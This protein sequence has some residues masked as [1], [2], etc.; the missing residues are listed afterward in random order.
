MEIEVFTSA[1]RHAGAD[2]LYLYYCLDGECTIV[3]ED[4]TYTLQKKDIVVCNPGQNHQIV[5]RQAMAVQIRFP[6]SALLSENGE[7][8][9]YISCCSTG[10][11]SENMER[12]RRILDR[13]LLQDT[14]TSMGRLHSQRLG[15]ELLIFLLS[16]F[17]INSRYTS[18]QWDRKSQIR[19]YLQLHFQEDLS[20]DQMADAFG[21]SSVYFSKYFK[22]NFETS[23]VKY[24]ARLRAE[25][26]ISRLETGKDSILDIGLDAGFP[27]INAYTTAFKNRFGMTPGAYR[28]AHSNASDMEK[29]PAENLR[30]YLD[31][32]PEEPEM[33]LHT[34]VCSLKENG[35]PLNPYWFYLLN[36]GSV[37]D[38]LTEKNQRFLREIAEDLPFENGRLFLDLPAEMKN[39]SFD[40][41]EMVLDRMFNLHLNPWL[42]LDFRQCQSRSFSLRWFERFLAYFSNRY[43]GRNMKDWNFEVFYNSNFSEAGCEE[44]D[45]YCE[46]INQSL[47]RAEL[48]QRVLGPG[49]QMD[50]DF[51]SLDNFCRHNTQI[52]H[53]TITLSPLMF[54]KDHETIYM[55]RKTSSDWFMQELKAIQS[56]AEQAGIRKVIPVSWKDSLYDVDV[57]N[58]SSYR[59]ARLIQIYLM[60]YNKTPSLPVDAAFHTAGAAFGIF[61]GD[62]GLIS[63]KGI[64]KPV[65]YG[66]KFLKHLDKTVNYEDGY[67]IVTSS[68]N[69]YSQ[70]IMQNCPRLSYTYYIQEGKQRTEQLEEYFEDPKPRKFHIELAGMDNGSYIVKE[71][72]IR[73]GEGNAYARYRQ[74]VFEDNSFFGP[75]EMRYL[76]ASSIP[77]I[78]GFR[79]RAE[80]GRI[81]L[82]LILE[83]NEV[84]HLHIVYTQ[85]DDGS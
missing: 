24:L 13:M 77:N 64:R 56:R 76:Q 45:R 51:H 15:C 9:K 83:P 84:R 67:A 46:Q 23:F 71:K 40:R 12:L 25:S 59:A 49:M 19:R 82:D 85:Q 16:Y 3:Q 39:V 44:Y 79:T 68:I 74:I 29:V 7:E 52:D 47:V 63:P 57:L 58:D 60:A 11:T 54:K 72:R 20:L 37:P 28:K 34:I 61:A 41:E 5:C 6:A 8:E 35:R 4:A 69:R 53:L 21:L 75:N 55:E 33:D 81:V 2:G 70:I 30:A 78:T 17:S 27:N 48:D 66:Y 80:D 31:H 18:L 73:W 26:T 36:V 14:A 38:L 50:A 42:V 22:E 1:C 43:G 62:P 10:D 32:A 65:Y